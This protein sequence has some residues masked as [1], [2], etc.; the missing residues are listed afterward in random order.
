VAEEPGVP[1]P[2]E[3]AALVALAVEAVAARL[4]GRHPR[5]GVPEFPRLLAT[6]ASF[7]TLERAGR[8]RGCIGTVAARRP[9]YLDVLRNARQAMTD[10]RLPPVT[11]ADW[12]Q[13]DVKVSVLS[14]PAPLPVQTR[15]ELVR[16]LRP[17]LD[18]LLLADG[19]RRA[20]FLPSVWVKLPDPVEFLDALLAKGG[21][22]RW[23]DELSVARYT[24]IEFVDPAPRPPL[25]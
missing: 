11:E 8:L 21:W 2:V 12:P 14:P 4:S 23:P 1:T 25:G 10:P 17:G 3:G 20:T 19:Q 24:S 7:V 22:A 9:L 6:G 5:P 18:G 13:L 15:A 16:L